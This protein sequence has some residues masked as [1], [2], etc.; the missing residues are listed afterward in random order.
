MCPFERKT[1]ATTPLCHDGRRIVPIVTRRI[2]RHGGAI[3]V[4]ADP[5]GIYIAEEEG[6]YYIPLDAG[7]RESTQIPVEISL[8]DVS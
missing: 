4:Q 1:F 3:V 7:R 6:G 2:V 5:V 8:Q